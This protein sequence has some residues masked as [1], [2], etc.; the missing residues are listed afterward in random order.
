MGL[1]DSVKARHPCVWRFEDQACQG[2]LVSGKTCNSVK[3]LL[4]DSFYPPH[5]NSVTEKILR[6]RA[7]TS[8]SDHLLPV[9]AAGGLPIEV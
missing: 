7:A 3:D 2:L 9:T 4:T 6:T 5:A 1:E 8:N